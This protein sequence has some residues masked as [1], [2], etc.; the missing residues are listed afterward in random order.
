MKVLLIVYLVYS[1]VAHS[2]TLS[3]VHTYIAKQI[4]RG[5]IV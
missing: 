5:V 1:Q 4:R 2:K 3:Y